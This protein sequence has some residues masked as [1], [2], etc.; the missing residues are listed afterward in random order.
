MK[1]QSHKLKK[2]LHCLEKKIQRQI[3]IEQ[4]AY[5]GR[6]RKRMIP[7]KKKKENKENSRKWRFDTNESPFFILYL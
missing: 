4:G 1:K 3:A 2:Q 6:F 7:N 5:D